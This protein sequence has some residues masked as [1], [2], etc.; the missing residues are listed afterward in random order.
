ML[1]GE[2]EVASAAARETRVISQR[3]HRDLCAFLPTDGDRVAAQTVA[4]SESFEMNA[5]K[6]MFVGVTKPLSI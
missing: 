4:S 6:C 5:A 1:A 3:A 2:I